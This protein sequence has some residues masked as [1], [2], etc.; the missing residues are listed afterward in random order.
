MWTGVL[1][2]LYQAGPK[3]MITRSFLDLMLLRFTSEETE[4]AMTVSAWVGLIAPLL[5]FGS[6]TSLRILL[7][8]VVIG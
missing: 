3:Y 4:Y 2:W 1:N 5:I 6:G 7:L 8:D